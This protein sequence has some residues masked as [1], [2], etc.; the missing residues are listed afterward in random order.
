M[1]SVVPV[2][3]LHTDYVGQFAIVSGAG[4]RLG[5]D[6]ADVLRDSGLPLSSFIVGL[7]DQS[8]DCIKL[9]SSDGDL[10]FMNCNGRQAMQVEEYDAIV[11]TSWIDIWPEAAQATVVQAIV[12]ARA[13]DTARF[14]A[15]GP[16]LKGSPRWWDVTV[17][18]LR[19]GGGKVVALLVASRDITERRMRED[20]MATI[21]AEMSHRLRNA[22]TV[23]SAL[24]LA[25]ARE[26]PEHA[27]FADE[28]IQRFARMADA[29]TQLHDAS[30]SDLGALVHR[31]ADA[32]ANAAGTLCVE[33]L[34][35]VQVGEGAARAIAL[36]VGE[37]CT[38]SIKYGAL[39]VGGSVLVSGAVGAG[40]LDARVLRL[41]WTELTSRDGVSKHAPGGSGK[42]LM[43]RMLRLHGGS[44]AS[45]VH[46]AGV[47]AVMTIPLKPN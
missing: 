1:T 30:G 10:R 40:P 14:E 36:A 12:A 28:L 20:S 19:D 43:A 39:G 15:F 8:E 7:F 5:R 33:A 47:D 34:P 13:G 44:F 26:A 24:T 9:L 22:Y 6:A 31:V 18:P 21:A 25:A 29:Q 3:E 11:G 41:N 45:D 23:S 16:T 46:E 4:P 17:S 35:V 27:R 37:L 42:R 32:F 38:N 2:P